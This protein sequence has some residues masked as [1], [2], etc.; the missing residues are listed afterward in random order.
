MELVVT[1][2]VAV[3]PLTI[4]VVA[5]ASNVPETPPL[6]NCTLPALGAA[7][8]EVAD[9]VAV[10]VTGCPVVVLVGLME[11]IAVVVAVPTD[12]VEP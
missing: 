2:N 10:K 11:E 4:S 7:D 8:P 6:R 12:K 1:V 3:V 5:V 9:T